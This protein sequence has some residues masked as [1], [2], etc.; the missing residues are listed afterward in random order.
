[1]LAESVAIKVFFRFMSRNE[2]PALGGTCSYSD[3][4]HNFTACW[5]NLRHCVTAAGINPAS[6][7]VDESVISQPPHSL[8]VIGCAVI[9]SYRSHFMASSM[10]RSI[11]PEL[12]GATP[13]NDK[14]QSTPLR[15]MPKRPLSFIH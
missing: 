14:S 3:A 12:S 1:M 15:P 5:H 10:C 7:N 6:V 8:R 2:N 13:E 9:V 11:R 4:D